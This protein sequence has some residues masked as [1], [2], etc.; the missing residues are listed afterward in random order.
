MVK[1]LALAHNP[2][3]TWSRYES[4]QTIAVRVSQDLEDQQ[5]TPSLS[6][7]LVQARLE[8]ELE[9]AK[10]MMDDKIAGVRGELNHLGNE[11]GSRTALAENKL[12]TLPGEL[13][14]VVVLGRV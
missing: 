1:C 10:E 6:P 12:A 11:L 8:K 13:Y 14:R 4:V 7:Q 3:F 5:Q 2:T 9:M